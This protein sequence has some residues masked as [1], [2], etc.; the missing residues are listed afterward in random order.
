[1]K[2]VTNNGNV[3]SLLPECPDVVSPGCVLSMGLFYVV[4]GLQAF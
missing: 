1:M 2:N 3:V 4:S